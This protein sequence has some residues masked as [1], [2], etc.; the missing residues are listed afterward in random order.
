VSA[1]TSSRS[2]VRA[3]CAFLLVRT[4]IG[5][6]V[7]AERLVGELLSLL[8]ETNGEF[9][10][11]TSYEKWL[12]ALLDKYGKER[13]YYTVMLGSFPLFQ[14]R[15]PEVIKKIIG[16]GKKPNGIYDLVFGRIFGEGLLTS[17]GHKWKMDRHALTPS[18]HFDA[19]KGYA[20][21]MNK[22]SSIMAQRIGEIPHGHVCGDLDNI[23]NKC[24]FDVIMETALGVELHAQTE[25][26]RNFFT[27]AFRFAAEHGTG[28]FPFPWLQSDAI[29]Y[30]LTPSGRH[31]QF[32][33]NE[34][35]KLT[36]SVIDN[37]RQAIADN[38]AVVNNGKRKSFL[39]CIAIR[40]F[41][42]A[43]PLVMIGHRAH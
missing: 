25:G 20:E 40:V 5:A 4:S 3:A 17:N 9:I 18:F 14:V 26:E 35:N 37:R 10:D 39:V 15:N 27:D 8:V 2:L 42:H 1:Q 41:V 6:S 13:G 32:V 22:Q 31:M 19:L 28:R 12:P 7:D 30:N 23:T 21:V 36:K 33:I 43:K 34:L 11:R 29:F 24:A 16:T 38:P